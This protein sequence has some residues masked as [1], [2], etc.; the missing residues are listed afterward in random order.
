MTPKRRR[1]PLFKN[2]LWACE[3]DGKLRPQRLYKTGDLL[4]Y[5]SDGSIDYIGRKDTQ[6]KIRG[7][8]IELYEVEHH[9][10]AHP[11]IQSALAVIPEMGPFK[12]SLVALIRPYDIKASSKYEDLGV[13]EAQELERLERLGHKWSNISSYLS[14]ILPAHMVPTGWIAVERLPLQ[15]SN[16]ADHAKAKSRLTT[17]PEKYRVGSEVRAEEAAPLFAHE[18][19]ANEIS[20]KIADL[21]AFNSPTLHAIISGHGV[22]LTAVG[23][24]SIQISSLAAFIK[25]SFNI[26]VGIHKLLG[27]HISVRD[28]SN[29]IIE[30][31]AVDVLQSY[32][33]TGRLYYY[34]A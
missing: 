21:V 9:L 11:Q 2:P 33:C 17:L 10:V 24:D 13:I 29:H 28:I 4:R 25:R 27:S 16:K 8:R 22:K 5:N 32:N 3:R 14:D 26:T 15:S 23:I 20:I 12:D 1:L 31:K 34:V 6:T 7:Q 18:V 19:V 30:G